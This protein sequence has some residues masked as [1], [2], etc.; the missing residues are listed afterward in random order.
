[1]KTENEEFYSGGFLILRELVAHGRAPTHSGEFGLSRRLENPSWRTIRQK[2][3]CCSPCVN[4]ASYSGRCKRGG[5]TLTCCVMVLGTIC[6]TSSSWSGCAS[7]HLM[8]SCFVLRPHTWSSE[9]PAKRIKR[10]QKTYPFVGICIA[11]YT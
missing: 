4:A 3:Y 11:A 6:K 1:M 7:P 8:G 9:A 10:N 2:D 5:V